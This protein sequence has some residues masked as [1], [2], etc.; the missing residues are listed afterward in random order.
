MYKW[1]KPIAL[2]SLLVIAQP[3]FSLENILNKSSISSDSELKPVLSQLEL[4]LYKVATVSFLNEDGDGLKKYELKLSDDGSIIAGFKYF[5]N[6]KEIAQHVKRILYI[7]DRKA[8]LILYI[9]DWKDSENVIAAY[10]VNRDDYKSYLD[11]WY[12]HYLRK[13]EEIEQSEGT[14]AKV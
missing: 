12:K 14:R 8:F 3:Q 9:D 7:T 6:P 11:A 4:D 2:A 13:Q 1:Y 10:E 5:L